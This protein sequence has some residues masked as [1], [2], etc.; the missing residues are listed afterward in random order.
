[1]S[2]DLL[3]SAAVGLSRRVCLRNVIQRWERAID[4]PN[5]HLNLNLMRALRFS[6]VLGEGIDAD[7]A[8][9]IEI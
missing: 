9:A 7:L 4:A 6:F 2:N 8:A 3:H 5:T 1:V